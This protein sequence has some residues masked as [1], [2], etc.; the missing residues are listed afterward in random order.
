MRRVMIQILLIMLSGCL[1]GLHGQVTELQGDIGGMELGP[2]TEWL[3]LDTVYVPDGT[4]L[5]ILPGTV[6][7]FTPGVDAWLMVERGGYI[8]AA[9]TELE[10]ITFTSA[11]EDPKPG[12]WLAP[13]FYG[14]GT[15]QN[16]DWTVDPT[17]DLGILQYIKME[18]SQWSFGLYNAGSETTVDH[19]STYKGGGFY[20]RG[21]EVS[22]NNLATL[23]TPGAGI[24]FRGGY[25]GQVN[26][27]FINGAGSRGIDIQNIHGDD[28]W[29]AAQL[30]PDLEPRTNPNLQ[31]VTVCNT[32]SATV[33]FRNGGVGTINNLLLYNH[34]YRWGASLRCYDEYLLNQISIDNLQSWHIGGDLWDWNADQVIVH[35]NVYEQDPLFAG[36]VPTD[37][38]G[39]GA[40]T[41]GDWLSS[42]GHSYDIDKVAFAGF[43]DVGG[44]QWGSYLGAWEPLI[45]PGGVLTLR[46]WYY[47]DFGYEVSSADVKILFDS[48]AYDVS[49]VYPDE[50]YLPPGETSIE[51]SVLADT[52][53][54]SF[55]SNASYS[56]SV[57]LFNIELLAN[58]FIG[59]LMTYNNSFNAS[60]NEDD[61]IQFIY[62]SWRFLIP[63]NIYG[64]VS[65]SGEISS[66]DA[67][68][69]LQ[70]LVGNTWLMDVQHYFGNVS[71][72]AEL[73]A[74]DASLI[75]QYMV[76][77]ITEFPVESGASSVPASGLISMIDGELFGPGETVEVPL[78]LSDGN[79]ILSFEAEINF[80]PEHLVFEE[81]QWSELLGD[82]IIDVN[83]DD[84]SGTLRAAGAGALPD[85]QTGIFAT[86][87]FTVD[88]AMSENETEVSVSSLRWNEDDPEFD[89]T[90]AMIVGVDEFQTKPM[91]YELIQNYP[92]PFNPE[93]NI[94]YA[95]PE[96]ADVKLIVYDLTGREIRT[97]RDAT[98]SAGWY[99]LKWD[100]L[101]DNGSPVN[102]GVYF[103]RLQAGSD[104]RTIKMINLK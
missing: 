67:A 102:S 6:I 37:V 93:T 42:W 22:L 5:T 98:Q 55:A 76:G 71:D 104:V 8:N 57:Y 19:I 56:G 89:I 92:N 95:L 11:A 43:N 21:G 24:Y 39:I 3:V 99:Q 74:Y 91:D 51:Y 81:I 35:E 20:I 79:N 46:A 7:K 96:V 78:L 38:T 33:R 18:Y 53:T 83:V 84:D 13:M 25:A 28:A 14:R 44:M 69:I 1:I 85:G 50:N 90:S 30:D 65:M 66:L 64:D 12:D 60:V 63:E 2:G 48:E 17:H 47:V 86:L 75:Q 10:P 26:E 45:V 103:T 27:L 36:L 80:N 72:D 73:T 62:D 68:L 58:E 82:F 15:G 97:L 41:T 70:N 101:D 87:V 54:V 16:P 88:Q 40:M 100:G 4:T 49:N 59:P 94:N 9:G 34:A 32:L 52:I 31:N 61:D 29:T 23:H 77:L